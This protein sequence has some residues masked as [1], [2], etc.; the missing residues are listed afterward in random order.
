M[1]PVPRYDTTASS[2]SSDHKVTTANQC[3]SADPNVFIFANA[4][5]MVVEKLGTALDERIGKS[6][7]TLGSS[8]SSVVTK[9]A[10]VLENTPAQPQV[11]PSFEGTCGEDATALRSCLQHGAGDKPS[12][13]KCH[14][15]GAPRSDEDCKF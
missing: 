8:F 9:M 10:A 14:E 1:D 3:P 11:C 7:D 12:I 2:D 15:L 5:N 4:L 13:A 6:L